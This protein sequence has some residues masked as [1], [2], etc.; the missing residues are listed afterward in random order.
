[1]KSIYKSPQ[2]REKIFQ[3]YDQKLASLDFPLE[4]K[5]LN[6]TYGQTRVIVSGNPKG[7]KVVLFHGVHAGSPLTL[8]C[9]K[10]LQKDYQFYAIDTIGQATKS[11]DTTINIKDESFALW[12][13]EVLD[14]LDVTSAHFIGISYGAYILQKLITHRPSKVEKC[15]FIVPSGLANGNFWPSMTKLSIPLMK[16]QFSKKDK[17]LRAFVKHFV[18]EE[19]TYMFEFQ[20][21]ILTG[22][23]MD[24][25]RPQ[26][27]QKKDVEHFTN[28]V[29][30]ILA[31]DDVFF[32][33][34]KV[35]KQAKV[36]FQNLKDVHLL[37]DCKHM[38]NGTHLFEMEQ[39][40]KQ[41]IG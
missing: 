16:Y 25:R 4:E 32:P 12:A 37:K 13:D 29:Y 40:I 22:L 10:G 34:D 11:A 27:L 8:E 17:D 39:K 7:Q 28:P 20:K 19:D 26:I 21:A 2:A 38:P 23:H 31:D 30:L 15:V 3:L 36:V 33:D 41:W 5:D 35:L 6:T 1:M 9:I 18:P 24:L 14:Q